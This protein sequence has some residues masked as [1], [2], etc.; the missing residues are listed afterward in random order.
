MG[1]P[2]WERRIGKKGRMMWWTDDQ[3]LLTWK[4]KMCQISYAKR[5]GLNK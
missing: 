4:L 3:M 5:F 1:L 2:I